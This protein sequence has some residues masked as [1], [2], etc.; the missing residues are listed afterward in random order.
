MLGLSPK[1]RGCNHS[2][3]SVLLNSFLLKED[4]KLVKPIIKFRTFSIEEVGFSDFDIVV[5]PSR[6]RAN[7]S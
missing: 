1:V 4:H 7:R 2:L 5:R 3:F 6:R